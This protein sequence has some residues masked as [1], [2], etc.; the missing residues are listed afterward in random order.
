MLVEA[1]TYHE[2]MG[3]FDTLTV[4]AV[5]FDLQNIL[6]RHVAVIRLLGCILQASLVSVPHGNFLER[7]GVGTR[8]RQNLQHVGYS[9]TVVS[10]ELQLEN[11]FPPFLLE[12]CQNP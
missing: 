8:C 11:N 5:V 3:Q 6:D 7:S 9:R 2:N 10:S 12:R 1:D 4:M